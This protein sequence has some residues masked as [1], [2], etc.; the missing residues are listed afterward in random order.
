MFDQLAPRSRRNAQRLERKMLDDFNRRAYFGATPL[1]RL[2]PRTRTRPPPVPPRH[3]SCAG[4]ASCW[5]TSR[6][7]APS[8]SAYLECAA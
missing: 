2:L 5:N 4:R 8:E 6:S 3:A 7:N 1:M